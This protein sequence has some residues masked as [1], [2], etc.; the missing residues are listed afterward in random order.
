MRACTPTGEKSRRRFSPFWPAFALIA[1]FE[2][3]LA[4]ATPP[5]DPI[6][7][8]ESASAG[9]GAEAELRS[10]LP[11]ELAH[12]AR[13]DASAWSA[14]GERGT[15]P[16]RG[17]LADTSDPRSAPAGPGRPL[18]GVV[19]EVRVGVLSHDVLFFN[20]RE[21]RFPDP[22]RHPFERGENLNAEILFEPPGWLDWV[23]APRPRL[24]GSVNLQGYTDNL[25]VDL[26]WDH[27]FR[28]GVFV[29]GFAGL[30]LHDGH[31]QDGNPGRA[32]LGSRLLFHL[33]AEVGYR[34]GKTSLSLFWEHM[35][36]SGLAVKN[37]GLDSIGLRCGY[38]FD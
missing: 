19:S 23:G 25:Y 22:F 10:H 1:V 36:N 21:L 7:S 11:Y 35:S 33:G 20:S 18:L 37:Q 6:P 4:P 2:P 38:R 28:L 32:E 26:D 29:E 16:V 27:A 12:A 5:A 9:P 14:G 34:L 24:G 17:G 15:P 31:L 30:A 3:A 8:S 13:P